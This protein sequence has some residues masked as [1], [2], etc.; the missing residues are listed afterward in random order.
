MNLF[1]LEEAHYGSRMK[2]FIFVSLAFSIM[3][4]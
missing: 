1:V 2:L 4:G 3:T